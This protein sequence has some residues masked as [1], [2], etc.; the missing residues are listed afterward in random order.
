MLIFAVTQRINSTF[1]L[2]LK[3]QLQ[4]LQHLFRRGPVRLKD[5]LEQLDHGR[6]LTRPWY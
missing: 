3:D 6:A 5:S 4:Y 2:G 1:V